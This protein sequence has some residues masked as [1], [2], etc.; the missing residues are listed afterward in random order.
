MLQGDVDIKAPKTHHVKLQITYTN[1]LGTNKPRFVIQTPE[2]FSSPFSTCSLYKYPRE[3]TWH[4]VW[5]AI[6]LAANIGRRTLTD[7]LLFPWAQHDRLNPALHGL[8]I[9]ELLEIDSV[10]ILKWLKIKLN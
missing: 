1:V 7:T 4:P 10:W 9:C 6:P 8:H 2:S 3:P 5:N